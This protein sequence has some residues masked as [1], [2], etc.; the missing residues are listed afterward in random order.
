MPAL[1]QAPHWT[2]VQGRPAGVGGGGG[3]IAGLQLAYTGPA[4]MTDGRKIPSR[5]P[6]LLW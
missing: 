1:D 5:P 6:A 2:E 4:H 3:G